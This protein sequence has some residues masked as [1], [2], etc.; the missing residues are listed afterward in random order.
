MPLFMIEHPIILLN[1]YRPKSNSS[2]EVPNL[3]LL[4]KLLRNSFP[5]EGLLPVKVIVARSS[6][7]K[8]MH[9]EGGPPLSMP[10]LNEIPKLVI[11]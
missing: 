10:H 6:P 3:N 9:D 7:T 1:P 8:L 5:K 4:D 11:N 2:K